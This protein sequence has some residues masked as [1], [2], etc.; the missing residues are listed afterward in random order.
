[1][2]DFHLIACCIQAKPKFTFTQYIDTSIVLTQKKGKAIRLIFS[3]ISFILNIVYR[4]NIVTQKND[5]E[6]NN[7]IRRTEV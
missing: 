3:C 6:Y 1:M 7:A 5:T 4:K 2:S